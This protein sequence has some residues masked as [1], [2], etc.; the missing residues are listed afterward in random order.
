M[1]GHDELHRHPASCECLHHRQ[2]RRNDPP[3][4]LGMQVTLHFIDQED[5]LLGRLLALPGTSAL[6]LAPGPDQQIGQRRNPPHARRC[7]HQGHILRIGHAQ[8]RLV[9]HIV[10]HAHGL[11]R[12]QLLHPRRRQRIQHLHQ[13]AELRHVG[14]LPANPVG[15]QPLAVPCFRLLGVLVRGQ[16]QPDLLRREVE[17]TDLGNF[18]VLLGPVIA[19]WVPHRKAAIHTRIDDHAGDRRSP[20]LERPALSA[21]LVDHRLFIG[22]WGRLGVAEGDLGRFG[23]GLRRC[24]HAARPGAG[25]CPPGHIQEKAFP[26]SVVS[27]KEVHP[28]RERDR[29]QLAGWAYARH[30]QGLQHRAPLTWG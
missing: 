15:D 8:R 5:D 27:R 1:R 6:V 13:V 26:E 29:T 28:W 17:G 30:L 10:A 21:V 2:Q 24:G 19:S 16:P 12:R 14:A 7:M 4:P 25:E 11:A 22:R 23:V 20:L 18:R 3:L 9:G